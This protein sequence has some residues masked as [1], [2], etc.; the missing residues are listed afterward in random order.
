MKARSFVE[1]TGAPW[2][3]LSALHGLVD[4]EALGKCYEKTLNEMPTA[5]RRRWADDVL[6]ALQP[7]LNSGD[8]VVILAGRKY[9]A[10]LTEELTAVG[11][12]VDVPMQDLR[13]GQQL[14][15]LKRKSS[16]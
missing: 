5:E 7:K 12:H 2:Y 11:V 3:I 16:T 1:R 14:A 6:A 10:F 8:T 15:W 4:P 13:Q 9:R